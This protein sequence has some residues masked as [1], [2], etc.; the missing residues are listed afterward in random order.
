MR[1]LSVLTAG[2]NTRVFVIF[3]YIYK[4][5]LSDETIREVISG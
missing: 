1:Y 2:V 4:A 3:H 5:F